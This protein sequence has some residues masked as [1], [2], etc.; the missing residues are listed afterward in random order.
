MKFAL[1]KNRLIDN[2]RLK[3]RNGESTERRLALR[4]G[5]SQSHVH[6]VLKGERELTLDVADRILDELG[7]SALDL[8]ER[9]EFV[10]YLGRTA[11]NVPEGPAKVRAFGR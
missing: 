5:L 4:M 7:M 6:N 3:M 1:M 2:V 8:V 9:S 11:V 10:A